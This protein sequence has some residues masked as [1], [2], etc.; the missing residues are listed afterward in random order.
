[1]NGITTEVTTTYFD[2]T[3]TDLAS[4]NTTVTQLN[5]SIS[6]TILSYD[7]YTEDLV[8]VELITSNITDHVKIVHIREINSPGYLA[9][10]TVTITN[11]NFG[12]FYTINL[13]ITSLIF[14][15]Y[16]A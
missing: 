3:K 8:K 4:L 2:N 6:M 15:I 14:L 5:G 11:M 12:V 1:V 9:T 10:E 16:M 13:V 7:E